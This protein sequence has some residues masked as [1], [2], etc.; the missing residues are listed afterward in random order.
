MC[1][2]CGG[3][4]DCVLVVLALVFPPLPVI[5][6]RGCC[7]VD[8]L[9][10]L[11][12]CTLGWVPGV[13]HA[14]FVILDDPRPLYDEERQL[15]VMVPSQSNVVITNQPRQTRITFK[16]PEPF[17]EEARGHPVDEGSL[18]PFSRS[19]GGVAPSAEVLGPDGSSIGP[20]GNQ[21]SDPLIGPTVG[22]FAEDGDF[23]EP[24]PSYFKAMGSK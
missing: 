1:C 14:W 2:C 12:L 15:L 13:I 21:S 6:K 11:L 16:H 19:Y 3:C 22:E 4:C 20:H 23:A 5:F 7:S 17:L 9:I 8:V 18:S 24:P 10:N